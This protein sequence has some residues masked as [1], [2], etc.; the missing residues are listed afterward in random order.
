MDRD[1]L[2]SALLISVCFGSIHA[3]GVLLSPIEK[4]LDVARAQTSAAYSVAII[5]ITLG[6]FITG[7]L[8]R[9]FGVGLTVLACGGIAMCGLA[10]SGLLSRYAGLVFGFGALYG[11]A[12]GIAYSLSLILAARSM[13][14]REGTAIGMTIAAYGL[15]AV[16]FAQIFELCLQLMAMPALLLA[17]GILSLTT[18]C[19]A[20]FLAGF[21]R[22]KSQHRDS[23]TIE[24]SRPSLLPLWIC[25][26]FAAFAGLMILAHGP[27]IAAQSGNSMPGL[28]AGLVSL[29]SVGGSYLGGIL[30]DRVSGRIGLGVP[31]LLQL[32]AVV[33]LAT[34]ASAS[35]ALFALGLA[36]VAYGAMT[37][38]V[39]VEVLRKSGP[40]WFARDYGRIVTAWGI[41]GVAG[42]IAAGYLYDLYGGYVIALFLAAAMSAISAITAT[43][44]KTT[45]ERPV[46]LEVG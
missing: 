15:G 9:S 13:P 42:P 24:A 11:V 33:C 32:V 18:C 38:A 7:R 14:G 12:N 46:S 25:Y 28:A 16:L 34:V 31:P 30:A 20:G 1:K 5:A 17:M 35:A 26:C 2:L 22:S 19:L 4:W 44:L 27:S 23:R 39:P 36:G 21:G 45:T 29:G 41:A 6:V 40:D 8:E 3:Y 37:S 10:L 43:L